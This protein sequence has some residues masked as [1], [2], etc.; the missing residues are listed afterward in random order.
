MRQNR[1]R[2]GSRRSDDD[3][4]KYIRMAA[5][6]LLAVI[7]LVIIIVVMDRKNGDQETGATPGTEI[8]SGSDINIQGD[9]TEG[10]GESKSVEPD[11][12]QYTTDFSHY[13]LQKDAVPAVNLLISD[14]FQAKIDQDAEKLFQLFG[15]TAD[16][17]LEA[18][19]EELKSEA[20]YIEDYQDIVCYT[21]PGL[22]E[23]SYVAYVTYEVKFRRVDTLAPG[24]MWCYVLKDDN[25]N[26]IIRENVVGDE[27]DYVAKQNQSE[28]VLLLSKQ[29]NE[30]LRQA[31]ESD[32]LLAGIY[33]DLRNGA[34]VSSSEEE[35]Q[36]S[37]V[38]LEDDA[39]GSSGTDES[40]AAAGTD[41]GADASQGAGTSGDGGQ[42]GAGAEGQNGAG[43]GA[44]GAGAG[45]QNG[46]GAGTQNGADAGTQSSA[47]TG[48]QN[49]GGGQGGSQSQGS[50]NGQNTAAET[51]GGSTVKIE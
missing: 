35:G 8:T 28:D 19:R 39:A 15:K 30:R 12:S 1:R 3:K 49:G 11:N 43:T 51:T 38:V 18:R 41:G 24:L 20:V 36:D 34:V 44:N 9:T 22:T 5:I 6:P 46:A 37:T 10:E 47:G 16:E 50:A 25:G 31:I 7:V 4:I 32:T 23:D 26:Y 29:V 2:T 14:Y 42:S 17:S 48:S 33:G 13:E 40:G 21:K 27:A 45:D